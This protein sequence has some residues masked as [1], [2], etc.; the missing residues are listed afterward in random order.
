MK[1]LMLALVQLKKKTL[2]LVKQFKKCD[3]ELKE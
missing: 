2:F 3:E 1:S